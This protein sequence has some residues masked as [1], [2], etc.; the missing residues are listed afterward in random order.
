MTGEYEGLIAY[1]I[2][3][4]KNPDDLL[5]FHCVLNQQNL[6]AKSINLNDSLE[7]IVGTTNYSCKCNSQWI[8]PLYGFI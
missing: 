1:I 5:L 8:I 2:K 4:D 7:K 3:N 6:C